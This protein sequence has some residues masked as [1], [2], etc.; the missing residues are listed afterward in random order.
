L[1]AIVFFL[2]FMITNYFYYFY[3]PWFISIAPT[4]WTNRGD[5]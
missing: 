1:H 3:E 4:K 5:L 2:F